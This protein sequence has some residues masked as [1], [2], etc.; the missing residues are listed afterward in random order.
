VNPY[1]LCRHVYLSMTGDAGILMD[2]RDGSYIGV[3]PAQAGVLSRLVT[4]W[5]APTRPPEDRTLKEVSGLVATLTQ[6]GLITDDT[7][8]GKEARPVALRA[9]EAQLVDRDVVES[10]HIR[11]HHLLN[12]LLVWLLSKVSLRLRSLG[13]VL[14]TEQ[15]RKTR[16]T[17]PTSEADLSTIRHLVNVFLHLRPFVYSHK[18]RCLFDSLVLIRFLARYHIFPQWVIGVK[19]D[20]F[21]AHSWVQLDQYSINGRP[22]FI[23]GFSPIVVI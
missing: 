6:R 13:A 2:L 18:D 23:Q 10:P 5:P 8:V 4:G 19:T 17:K 12:L 14:R 20:P 11:F 22:G 16:L 15:K 9:V 7:S 3:S 1:Y 21:L